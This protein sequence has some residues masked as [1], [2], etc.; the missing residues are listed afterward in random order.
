MRAAATSR[1]AR[2]PGPAAAAPRPPA[3][4]PA[5]SSRTSGPSWPARAGRP[6]LRTCA[7][8]STSCMRGRARSGPS[9]CRPT[10]SGTACGWRCEGCR[11]PRVAV[12]CGAVR[13]VGAGP[14]AGLAHPAGAG[15]AGPA[16]GGRPGRAAGRARAGAR[17]GAAAAGAGAGLAA[18]GSGEV[19]DPVPLADLQAALGAET[20]LV[21]YVVTAD[22]VVGAGGHRPGT[23]RHDLGARD[24]LE[25]L[26]SGLLPD[27]DMAR[28][29]AAFA[30]G[31][32]RARGAGRP[33]RPRSRTCSSLRCS[34]TSATGRSC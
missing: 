24:R 21:A 15:A 20:A 29:R 27:L 25:P 2:A 13:V 23:R 9:T 34:P 17:G 30:V 7:P 3:G 33:G 31:W 5:R 19:S 26:L 22:R 18:P 14:D 11:S 1:G 12:G 6:A 28:V 32:L 4:G 8:D 10:W 16:D